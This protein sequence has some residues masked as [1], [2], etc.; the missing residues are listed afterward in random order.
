MV[1][2]LAAAVAAVFAATSLMKV[3]V[4]V[5][6]DTDDTIHELENEDDREDAQRIYS[7][8]AQQHGLSSLQGLEQREQAL[9]AAATRSLDPDEGKRRTASADELR[10]VVD[11]A[12][13]RARWA[14]VRRRAARASA[15]PMAIFRYCVVALGLL[16]FAFLSDVATAH[17][18]D[19]VA[20]AKACGEARKAGAEGSD[21]DRTP[22]Q[23]I[24]ATPPKPV[25]AKPTVEEARASVASALIASLNECMKPAGDDSGAT[26][27]PR[28]TEAE[29]VAIIETVAGLLG[30]AGK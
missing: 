6:L 5:V 30:A 3:S 9:R 25:A 13:S 11:R 4:P 23:K 28:P 27:P 1:G 7:I 19:N 21:F 22:C 2:L 20:T 12:L 14:V 10:V 15:G 8:V 16:A 18:T 26:S 17:T 29:C 24:P